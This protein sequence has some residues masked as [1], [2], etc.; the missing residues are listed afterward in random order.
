MNYA[1]VSKSGELLSLVLPEEGVLSDGR[2]VSNYN[3]LDDETLREEGWLPIDDLGPPNVDQNTKI[4]TKGFEV[5]GNKVVA[6]YSVKDKPQPPAE[7]PVATVEEKLQSLIDSL[8]A[9]GTITQ[10]QVDN[11]INKQRPGKQPTTP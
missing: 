3:K 5:R 2:H 8:V 6:V 10:A 9:K 7:N 1:Q 11:V 4:V